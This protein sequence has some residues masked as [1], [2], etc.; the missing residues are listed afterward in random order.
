MQ[1]CW[2]DLLATINSAA[3][4][5]QE[6][7]WKS[8]TTSNALTLGST[9]LTTGSILFVSSSNAAATTGAVITLA[10]PLPAPG[11]ASR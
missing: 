11:S 2:N 10:T 1:R 7:D 9:S 5:A 4:N 3:A 8:L 6:W